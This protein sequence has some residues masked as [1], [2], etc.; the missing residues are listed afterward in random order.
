MNDT[1]LHSN[2]VYRPMET[3]SSKS[4]N[5]TDTFFLRNSFFY[6]FAHKQKLQFP[7]GILTKIV[8]NNKPLKMK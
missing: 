7:T 1:K 5:F 2:A 6:K 8:K 3:V 4:K